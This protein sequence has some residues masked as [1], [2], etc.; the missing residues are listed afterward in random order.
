M[1]EVDKPR[2][3][4]R[5]TLFEGAEIFFIAFTQSSRDNIKEALM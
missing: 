2:Y 4:C 5:T 1:V 3:S